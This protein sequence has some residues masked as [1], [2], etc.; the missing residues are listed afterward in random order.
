MAIYTVTTSQNPA[1][2]ILMADDTLSVTA[3]GALFGNG[4]DTV[5][6]HFDN[7]PGL[8]SVLIEGAIQQLPGQWAI[9]S[10]GRNFSLQIGNDGLLSAENA[11]ISGTL[12]N[13]SIE[14]RGEIIAGYKAIQLY[15]DTAGTNDPFII[16]NYGRIESNAANIGVAAITLFGQKAASSRVLDIDNEGWIGGDYAISF[17]SLFPLIDTVRLD[18]RNEAAGQIVGAIDTSIAAG[19]DR[20]WNEGTISGFEDGQ[21][22]LGGGNDRLVNFGTVDG[23]VYLQGGDDIYRGMGAGSV[24][25]VDGGDGNDSLYGGSGADIFRGGNGNDTLMGF[26]GDDTFFADAGFDLIIGGAG[27]DRIML[28]DATEAQVLDLAD[29]TSNVGLTMGDKISGIEAITGSDFDDLLG[30]THIANHI[31]GGAG[32]DTLFGRGGADTLIGGAGDDWIDGGIGH[33]HLSGGDG[34]DYLFGGRGADTLIGGDGDDTLDGGTTRDNDLLIGGD[35]V[36]TFVLYRTG[37]KDVV[38][39]LAAEDRIELSGFDGETVAAIVARYGSDTA[40]GALLR[41]SGADSVLFIDAE[42]EL[43]ADLLMLV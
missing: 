5:V 18:L 22:L 23:W 2:H 1:V 4:S 32:N 11:F 28:S 36:D 39:D 34:D 42:L 12:E 27:F 15:D 38:Q 37:G 20:I 21:F 40:D 7:N 19:N 3:S 17:A 8:T 30:G 29:T 25:G 43:V 24:M 9:S 14:N 33:D 13:L 31:D 6:N 10:A 41:F 35:G 16:E 26:G